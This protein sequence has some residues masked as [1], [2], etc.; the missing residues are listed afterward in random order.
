MI[1]TPPF[2]PMR[3]G[4]RFFRCRIAAD[5]RSRHRPAIHLQRHAQCYSANRSRGQSISPQATA[6]LNYFPEPNLAA[7]STINGY[8]YH[9]LTTAQS[10]SHAGRHSLQPQPRRK[11]HAARR[12]RGSGGGRRGGSQNQGLRQSIN[13]N[14]NWSHSA[15]DMV[16]LDSGPGRQERF[17]FILS[18]GRLHRRLSPL[19]Q[20]LER[21]LESQQQP[22]HELLHQHHQQSRGSRGIDGPQ[23]RT[24]QLRRARYF[25]QQWHSGPERNAAQLLHRADHL[26]QRGPELDSRQAQHAFRRRLPAR[27]PRLSRRLER[28]RELRF[29]WPVH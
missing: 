14:Y 13:L 7:G 9:L 24:A 21:Q 5:L 19:H 4:R 8:N 6:L 22:H 23:Q 27:A 16:N 15:S 2:P 29:H 28:Y 11:R 12:P 3:S 10:N 1:S 25:A 20:H 26:V 17:D 18:A